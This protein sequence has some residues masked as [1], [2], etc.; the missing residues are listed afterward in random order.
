[1]TNCAYASNDG[2]SLF[3]Y[4]LLFDFMG[5]FSVSVSDEDIFPMIKKKIKE[6]IFINKTCNAKKTTENFYLWA[7]LSFF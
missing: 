2:R 6:N 7:F 4:F 3:F 5:H 1:M